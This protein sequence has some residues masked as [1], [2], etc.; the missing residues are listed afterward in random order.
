MHSGWIYGRDTGCSLF[1]HQCLQKS[2]DKLM[3]SSKKEP[4]RKTSRGEKMKNERAERS[5]S[6]R[7]GTEREQKK[8]KREREREKALALSGPPSDPFVHFI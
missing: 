8:K 5:G 6:G 1:A 2:A 7:R 4:T 3:R